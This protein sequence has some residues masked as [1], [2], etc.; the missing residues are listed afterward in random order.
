MS[1]VEKADGVREG[2]RACLEEEEGVQEE[3]TELNPEAED[4]TEES[5]ALFACFWTYNLSQTVFLGNAPRIRLY[6]NL[7]FESADLLGDIEP[8]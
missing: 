1:F 7:A 4:L 3:E 8:R 6:A 5:R 2:K